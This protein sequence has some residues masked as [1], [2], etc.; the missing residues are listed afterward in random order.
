[1]EYNKS[2]NF[3]DKA[4]VGI[5]VVGEQPYAEGVAIKPT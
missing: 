3:T 5:V 4:D 2:G 1:V